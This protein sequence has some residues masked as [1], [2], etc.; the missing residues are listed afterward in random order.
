MGYFPV[1]YDAR[2]VI[3]ERKLFIRLATDTIFS[4]KMT[5]ENSQKVSIFFVFLFYR[6]LGPHF[7]FKLMRWC[8]QN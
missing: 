6:K 1:R 2:V 5:L 3:Y 8:G 4:Q 7:S